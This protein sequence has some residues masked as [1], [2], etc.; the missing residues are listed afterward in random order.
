MTT[1]M[2]YMFDELNMKIVYLEVD[3]ENTAAIACYEK[4]GFVEE[5]VLRCKRYKRGEYRD[6]LRLSITREEWYG[7]G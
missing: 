5:G 6:H 7:D 1:L 4:C 2:D 3:T